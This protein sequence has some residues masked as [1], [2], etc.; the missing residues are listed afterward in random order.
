MCTT[1]GCVTGLTVHINQ[2]PAGA[3][4]VEVF[5]SAT[6]AQPLATY[7]CTD[8]NCGPDTQFST[9]YP[10]N[11]YIK[12]T[13]SVGVRAT[14]FSNI[15]YITTPNPNGPRCGEPCRHA[16]VTVDAPV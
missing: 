4:R 7:D 5:A 8:A 15:A 14:Q 16:T 13:M 12:V 11:A 10:A 3:F 9:L 1:I 6:D 2:K